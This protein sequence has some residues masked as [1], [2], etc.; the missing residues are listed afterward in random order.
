MTFNYPALRSTLEVFF[1][2]QCG[3]SW[4]RGNALLLQSATNPSW[5]ASIDQELVRALQD[6]SADWQ[7]GLYNS[8]YEVL[9]FETR[10]EARAF[11]I[12]ILWDPLHPGE[13]P[14]S[15]DHDA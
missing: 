9:E 14:P 5:R 2:S 15:V 10:D 13:A 11:A 12:S 4:E 3:L 7:E 1:S 8:Q 6:P